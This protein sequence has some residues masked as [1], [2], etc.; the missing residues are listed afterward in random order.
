MARVRKD[1]DQRYV[2]RSSLVDKDGNVIKGDTI[3]IEQGDK[4]VDG[5]AANSV[6]LAS[7]KV[8]GGTASG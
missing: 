1:N 3:T 4:N 6:Y 7:Q 2:L 5:G 8:D